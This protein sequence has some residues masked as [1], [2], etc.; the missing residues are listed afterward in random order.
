[1][2]IAVFL[3]GLLTLLVGC[4]ND[5]NL[6]TPG[7]PEV[8]VME[9]EVADTPV[10]FEFVAKTASSRKVEIRSRVEGF[11]EE[12]AYVE[13]SMVEEGQILFQMDQKPFKARLDAAKAELSQQLA[14]LD[15]AN[16]NLKRVKPLA[17]KNAV[18]QKE[19]DD[20]LGTYRSAAAAVEAA[21]ANVVQAELDLGYTTIFSP[22]K[23][24][25]SYAVNREGAYI[26]LGGNSLL[27]YVAQIDPMWV[28]FSVS[29]SQILTGRQD[30]AKGIIKTPEDGSYEV[31]IRLSDG[32]VYPIRGRITFADASLS[33][34]TG[35]FLIRA[36]IANPDELLRPGQFVRTS[37]IGAIRP[38][39]ILVPQ[40]AVQQG[41]KGSFVWVIKEDNTAEFRPIQTGPWHGDQWFVEDGLKHGEKVVVQGGMKLQANTPVI[42]VEPSQTDQKKKKSQNAGAG[43][44]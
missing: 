42:I 4:G 33:E 9:V 30:E 34:D 31:E 1:M 26:G 35:T 19:L 44:S 24:V 38:N 7:M 27:T 13:G 41:A 37:L 28:E 11:L 8:E 22:L 17:E 12:I 6:A 39:A 36:E 29:E 43:Q 3:F 21:R 18:A 20:A 15:T 10:T 23:G 5:E 2:K 16:A 14:R 25:S 40:Q 32:M